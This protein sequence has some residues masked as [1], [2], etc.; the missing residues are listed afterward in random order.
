MAASLDLPDIDKGATYRHTLFWKDKLKAPINLTGVTARMQVR[1]NIDSSV[2]ILDLSTSN[3]GITITPLL[4][5]IDI[6]V[7]SA[8]TT[9]LPGYGGV[10]DM[11]LIFPT[12]DI[13]RLI[14]G[15]VNFIPEV[16]R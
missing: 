16:T 4:G 1:D 15:T 7:S 12:S 6:Y 5:R 2:A 3:G 9:T 13:I 14:E 11:E 8:V 10:Y